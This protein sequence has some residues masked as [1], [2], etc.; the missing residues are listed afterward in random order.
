MADDVTQEGTNSPETLN[1]SSAPAS[2]LTP[3]EQDVAEIRELLGID[4]FTLEPVNDGESENTTESEETVSG[5]S[6]DEGDQKSDTSEGST[7]DSQEGSDASDEDV[8]LTD[9]AVDRLLE[10][11][12]EEKIL[13]RIKEKVVPRDEVEKTVNEQLSQ[14]RQ[15]QSV[16]EETQRLITEGATAYKTVVNAVQKAAEAL[17]KA[18]QGEEFETQV[19]DPATITNAF[20][21]FGTAVTL[22]TRREYDS[23]FGTAFKA[24]WETIGPLSEDETA[25]VLGFVQNASRIEADPEQGSAA[26]K[27]Y[28]MSETIKFLVERANRAGYEKAM[29]EVQSRRERVRKAIG[30]DP[31][32]AAAVAKVTKER[33]KAPPGPIRQEPRQEG[34]GATL[35]DYDAAIKAGDYELA[36]QIVARMAASRRALGY[37]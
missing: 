26:A 7:A 29:Q 15:A 9:E 25:K 10:L 30:D 21:Q 34:I 17:A 12:P 16:E 32:L 4:P 1:E 18:E 13:E 33:K 37:S 20:R 5:E 35:D 28:L 3:E 14:I 27:S 11:V 31:V 24:G 2:A 8:E 6:P 36:D 19:I 22:E 23:A